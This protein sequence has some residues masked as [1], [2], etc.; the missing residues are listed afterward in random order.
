MEGGGSA[1][2]LWWGWARLGWHLLVLG[3]DIFLGLFGVLGRGCW[4]GGVFGSWCGNLG[5][6]IS[7]VRDM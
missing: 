2:V 4:G 5:L 7:K 3:L 1:R 6:L